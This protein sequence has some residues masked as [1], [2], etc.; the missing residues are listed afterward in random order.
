MTKFV[1]LVKEDEIGTEKFPNGNLS[2]ATPYDDYIS[3]DV[4]D[5]G[6]PQPEPYEKTD[7]TG[8][9]NGKNVKK[10][11]LYFEPEPSLLTGLGGFAWIMQ[12]LGSSTFN[13]DSEA[14]SIADMET[15]DKL[16]ISL[17][18]EMNKSFSLYSSIVYEN[19]VKY[20]LGVQIDEI[21]LPLEDGEVAVE[22]KCFASRQILD[23]TN[24]NRGLSDYLGESIRYGYLKDISL[25]SFT[26][27]GSILTV[28]T[29]TGSWTSVG[30]DVKS[31]E[32]NSAFDL[33]EDTGFGFCND[34]WSNG[35]K[36]GDIK[37]T[38]KV[39]ITQ[40]TDIWEK[41]CNGGALE[42]VNLM[43][44]AVKYNLNDGSHELDII[45]PKAVCSVDGGAFQIDNPT[46]TV[47]FENE[48]ANVSYDSESF[49]SCEGLLVLTKL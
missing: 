11:K 19:A 41:L 10:D 21:T 25:A 7:K 23:E 18:D 37:I 34:G 2:S 44:K 13:A 6:M 22:T 48:T 39:E 49:N 32:F 4:S 35:F 29:T 5:G 8:L 9:T 12:S 43:K 27:S 17:N 33:D 38:S 24:L 28:P 26:E 14:T 20:A 40:G 36:N 42:F 47:N 45:S 15:G 31:A 16:Y 30:C 46:E 1:T 3:S